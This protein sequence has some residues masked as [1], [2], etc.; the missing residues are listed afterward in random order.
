MKLRIVALLLLTIVPVCAHAGDKIRIATQRTGTFAWELAIM[1]ERGFDKAAGLDL[2][3]VELA[4]PESGKIALRGGSADL[5][6]TDLVWIARQRELGDQLMFVPFSTTIGALMVGPSSK[7]QSLA[8]LKG[9]R[10]GV[11][12]GPLDKSYVLLTALARRGGI[13]LARSARLNFGAPPLLHQKML[14]GELDAILTYWNFAADL[15]SRGYRKLIGMDDVQKQLGAT[16]PAAMLGYGF[17]ARFAKRHGDALDRFFTAAMRAKNVLVH[18][19]DAWRSLQTRTGVSDPAVLA[20][21]QRLYAGGVPRND[22][23]VTYSDAASIY[24]LLGD[25]SSGQQLDRAMF[26]EPYPVAR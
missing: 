24:Q 18:E 15:E 2:E 5:I 3:V 16:H 6:V 25:S 19:S 10:L 12:G 9:A 21:Y 11:A 1:R 7:M 23:E 13:D 20:I 22:R 8:D 17:E 26:Y 4:T 14:Q